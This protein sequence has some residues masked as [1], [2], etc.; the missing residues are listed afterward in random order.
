MVEHYKLNHLA[1]EE[2]LLKFFNKPKPRT[3]ARLSIICASGACAELVQ[4]VSTRVTVYTPPVLTSGPAK[5]TAIAGS[6][7]AVTALRKT[8]PARI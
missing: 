4:K 8:G 3:Q 5:R 7:L 2:L 6:H 1:E